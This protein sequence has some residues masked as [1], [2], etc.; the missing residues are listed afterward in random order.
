MSTEFKAL[1]LVWACV[2]G[3][4]IPAA[5]VCVLT[6][7]SSM[8]LVTYLVALIAAFVLAGWLVG[9]DSKKADR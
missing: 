7:N 5:G 3:A 4:A 6:D 2:L 1:L 9:R 8:T